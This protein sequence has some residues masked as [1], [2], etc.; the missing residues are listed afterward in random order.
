MSAQGEFKNP[1]GSWSHRGSIQLHIVNNLN[2][3][4]YNGFEDINAEGTILSI[5]KQGLVDVSVE[6][7]EDGLFRIYVNGKQIQ[8][9]TYMDVI[10][11]CRPN[12]QILWQNQ[13]FMHVAMQ[14]I[15]QRPKRSS[16]IFYYDG[17]RTIGQIGNSGSWFQLDVG[18]QIQ[19]DRRGTFRLT[20]AFKTHAFLDVILPR[21]G[22]NP[23]PATHRIRIQKAQ[24]LYVFRSNYYLEPMNSAWLSKGFGYK[25]GHEP[26]REAE[27][28]GLIKLMNLG[29]LM[30]ERAREAIAK[31]KPKEVRDQMHELRQ[32]AMRSMDMREQIE[33]LKVGL[34]LKEAD[35]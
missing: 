2:P 17:K 5:G 6:G 20:K 12:G 29:P 35:V 23:I 7:M 24:C 3:S 31:M 34:S 1:E 10:R 15:E 33:A 27:V 25:P 9:Y 16:V 28:D 8:F 19:F 14:E 32:I 21:T 18:Q 26:I 22:W 30:E 4:V 13:K 11:L